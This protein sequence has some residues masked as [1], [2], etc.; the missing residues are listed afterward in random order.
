MYMYLLLVI[1]EHSSGLTLGRLLQ[2]LFSVP[3][4]II[5]PSSAYPHNSP[6]SYSAQI[7]IKCLVSS[8]LG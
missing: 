5:Q 8:T 2:P 3:L 4:V 7:S 6:A 1:S